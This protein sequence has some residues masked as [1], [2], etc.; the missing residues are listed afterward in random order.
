MNNFP[1]MTEDQRQELIN[2]IHETMEI[3]KHQEM[4]YRVYKI[5]LAALTAETDYVRYSCWC[6]GYE[7]LSYKHICPKCNHHTLHTDK[8]YAAPPAP[9]LKLPDGWKLV[10]VEPTKEMWD[11]Y[12]NAPDDIDSEWHAM[13]MAAPEASNEQ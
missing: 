5:A 3:F 11:A 2:H 8:L 7:S 1:A 9:V 13:L 12:D 10:P 4:I 6:C